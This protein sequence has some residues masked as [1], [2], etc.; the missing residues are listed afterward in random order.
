VAAGASRDPCFFR[1]LRVKGLFC[2]LAGRAAFLFRRNPVES[3]FLCSAYPYS[4]KRSSR[5]RRISSAILT[6]CKAHCALIRRCS[7]A[8]TSMVNRFM[9]SS[10]DTWRCL[11]QASAEGSRAAGAGFALMATFLLMGKCPNLCN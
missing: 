7:R 5:S 9:G 6:P 4:G 2:A 11:T 10:A 8:G 1:P 3:A